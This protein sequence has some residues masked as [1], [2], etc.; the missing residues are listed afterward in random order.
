MVTRLSIL[1]HRL[2]LELVGT[3]TSS[4]VTRRDPE[5]RATP[6]TR[7]ERPGRFERSGPW[8]TPYSKSA[9][10][11]SFSQVAVV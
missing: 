5:D 1:R 9:L 7:C 2:K 4:V 10:V 11:R 3:I 6:L 8:H